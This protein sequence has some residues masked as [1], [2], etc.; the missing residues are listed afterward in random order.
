VDLYVGLTS[1]QHWVNLLSDIV[2]S[3]VLLTLLCGFS[4]VMLQRKKKKQQRN[5]FYYFM[6]HFRSVEEAKG[7][8]FQDGWKD[9]A[10]KAGPIW[11]VRQDRREHTP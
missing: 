10:D 1:L 2:K 9:V 11:K 8:K 7:V 3:S 6:V 4:G 5:A